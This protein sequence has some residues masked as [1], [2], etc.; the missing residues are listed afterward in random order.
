MLDNDHYAVGKKYLFLFPI[1]H[2]D[3]K[4]K[5]MGDTKSGTL[6]IK[7]SRADW[8]CFISSMKQ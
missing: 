5:K 7:E 1:L 6:Y 4:R 3:I 8:S 2:L